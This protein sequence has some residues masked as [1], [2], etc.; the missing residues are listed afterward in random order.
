GSGFGITDENLQ[1]VLHAEGERTTAGNGAS[2]TLTGGGSTDREV[3][4][5]AFAVRIA[6]PGERDAEA[7][8]EIYKR[9]W[10]RCHPHS[11]PP[12]RN[13]CRRRRTASCRDERS[14]RARAGPGRPA[15]RRRERVRLAYAC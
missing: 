10:G 5:L 14:L 1:L 12:N 13:S 7:P 2:G 11:L 8:G 4:P 3:Q 9:R 6:V 15:R